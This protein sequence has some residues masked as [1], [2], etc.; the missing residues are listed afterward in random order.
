M[1]APTTSRTRFECGVCWQIY[2]PELGDPV[3]QIPPGVAFEELPDSW[4][5]PTCDS[6][7]GKFLRLGDDS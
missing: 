2:D 6:P 3:W 1:S 7:R 5:C 4:C